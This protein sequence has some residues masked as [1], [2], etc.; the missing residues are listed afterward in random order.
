M[1]NDALYL[2]CKVCNKR[3]WP[4]ANYFPSSGIFLHQFSTQNLKEWIEEHSSCA[5]EKKW[6]QSEIEVVPF[7]I[8]NQAGACTLEGPDGKMG[9]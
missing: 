7:E 5:E 6:L 9:L 8:V 2:K 4:F 3:S 1:P